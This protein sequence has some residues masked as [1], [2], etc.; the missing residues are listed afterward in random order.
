[1]E[2]TKQVPYYFFVN[3]NINYFIFL[4]ALIYLEHNKNS[5][6]K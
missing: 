4:T 3:C 1:M 2:N 6:F 5:D